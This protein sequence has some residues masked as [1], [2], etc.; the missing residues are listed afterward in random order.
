MNTHNKLSKFQK[1]DAEDQDI[2]GSGEETE[3][4]LPKEWTHFLL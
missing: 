4:S 2:D 3:Q 1:E